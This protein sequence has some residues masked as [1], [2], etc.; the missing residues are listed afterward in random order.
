MFRNV[1]TIGENEDAGSLTSLFT[2]S[3]VALVVDSEKHLK[4]VI[5]KMDLVD[6]LSAL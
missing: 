1:V 3:L 5:T 6:Y 2:E 4:G